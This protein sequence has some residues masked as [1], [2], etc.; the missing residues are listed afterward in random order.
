MGKRIPLDAAV[1]S[2]STRND[3]AEKFEMFLVEIG[4]PVRMTNALE[5]RGIFTVLDLLDC[6]HEDILSI[7]GVGEASLEKIYVALEG[8]GFHRRD[9]R[10]ETAQRETED[11]EALATSGLVIKALIVPGDKTKEG[12]LV[13]SVATPWFAIIE[14]L[15]RNPDIVYEIGW[16]KWEEIVAGAYDKAGFDV[17]LTP[18]SGDQGRDVIASKP[19][20][21]CIRIFDQVKAYGPGHL[22]T[23]DE[24]RSM[25]GTI[26]GSAN[27]SKG[28]ITT[29]SSFA[30]G[31]TEADNIKPF[32]PYR[33]ELRAK[34]AL[35]PWLTS[36]ASGGE[37][38]R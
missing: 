27:V 5:D 3:V 21:G 28:V 8:L 34:D 10:Q 6:T 25:L 30:P 18:R 33:L 17:I 1:D 23:A 37:I 35:I 15:K 24:V 26:T 11:L 22:V 31:V 19:G 12:T 29:T 38:M 9:K 13:R 32:I 20:I 7:R 2:V 36:L 14:L 4:L 16:R